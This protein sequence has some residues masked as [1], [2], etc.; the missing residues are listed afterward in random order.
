MKSPLTTLAIAGLAF[1]AGGVV[2][3]F[4][5]PIWIIPLI[6]I[7]REGSRSDWLSFAGA[8]GGSFIASVVGAT[9]IYFASRGIRQQ[10][11]VALYSREEDRIETDLPG[12]R[13]AEQLVVYYLSALRDFDERDA[14]GEVDGLSEVIV[15]EDTLHARVARELPN[16]T[17]R[18]RQDVEM[19]LSLV[20]G[21]VH[22]MAIARKE[23]IAVS[24]DLALAIE[25]MLPP[26]QLQ[27]YRNRVREKET[28]YATRVESFRTAQQIGES[29][30]RSINGRI[31]T[32]QQRLA[33][34]RREIERL[35][36]SRQ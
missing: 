16:A 36:P 17:A 8:M 24:R 33:T 3:F 30:L 23:F 5:L 29:H 32:M 26:P 14:K 1:F 35:L 10:I 7:G 22:A 13:E 18:M 28:E 34:Y 20:C 11:S 2:S 25:R 9:A 27:D 4:T 21:A 19:T 15:L 6:Q 31:V 12:L